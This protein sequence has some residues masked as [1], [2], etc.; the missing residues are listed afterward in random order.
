TLQ[1]AT[2]MAD[3]ARWV[4]VKNI[5]GLQMRCSPTVGYMADLIAEGFIGEIL[6]AT[7]IGSGALWDTVIDEANSYAAARSN[8]AK[9]LSITCAHTLGGLCALIGEFASIQAVQAQRRTTMTIRQTGQVIPFDAPD[10]VL[11]SGLLEN[12]VPVSV[13]YRGGIR[14]GTKLLI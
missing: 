4:G 8:G 12:G 2:T 6:S 13:H 10:Q 9:L 14:G 1:E 3:H 11:F 7:V 5:V